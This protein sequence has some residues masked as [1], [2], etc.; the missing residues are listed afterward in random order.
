M[1]PKIKF[2]EFSAGSASF[3]TFWV[4]GTDIAEMLSMGV[5]KIQRNA[6]DRLL[7][8]NQI[9]IKEVSREYLESLHLN[10]FQH[11]IEFVQQFPDSLYTL[12]N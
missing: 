10:N 2:L 11:G 4:I 7:D 12:L 1:K 6:F 8:Q 5:V 9:R 3:K